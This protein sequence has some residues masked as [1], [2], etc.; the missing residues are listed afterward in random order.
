MDKGAA[1]EELREL[2]AASGLIDPGSSVV[3]M[4][5]GGADSAC[6]AAGVARLLGAEP[7][8]ALHVNYGLREGA[9]AAEAACRRLCAALR[10][11]LHIERPDPA[12]LG[13]GNLQAA[14]RE[15]R[16]AAAERLRARTG[17]DLVVTGHTLTDLAETVVYRLSVSPGARSLLGLAPRTGRVV[18]PL[19]ELS[20]ERARELATIAGLAFADDETNDDP[21]FARNRIRSR[22]LPE[23]RELN[24][25]A[26]RNVAATRAELAEEAE[27]LDRVV[28]E[29]LD[30]AGASAG[31][32]AVRSAELSAWEPALRR[33]ALRALAERAAGRP[34]ALG[35]AR[36]AEILRLASRP[37]GGDVDLGGGLTAACE[38]GFARAG[39]ASA[40]GSRPA[41]ALGDPRRASPE[42][43]RSR[44]ARARDARRRGACRAGRGPDLARRRPDQAARNGGDEDPRRPVHRPAGAALA[45]AQPA[46]RHGRRRGRVGGRGRG[47]RRL[48]DRRRDRGGGGAECKG[49]RRVRRPA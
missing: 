36:T 3:V 15:I 10:L 20:R 27:L 23:L 8:H 11:D 5:S 35:S 39:G 26:E 32:V 2:V 45:P 12:L 29:A 22:V 14:A 16:Y 25:A 24:P 33:L 44:R 38:A 41:R 43:G 28:L 18:R 34:V 9:G 46:G 37:E 48:P 7:V 42:P 19:L 49:P 13:A 47:L 30:D 17:A 6:A 4:T 40:S 31:A 1:L 21:A